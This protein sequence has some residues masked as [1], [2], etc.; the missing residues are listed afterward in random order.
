[1]TKDHIL[2][3]LEGLKD[4]VNASGKQAIDAIKA[5]VHV[6]QEAPP[7]ELIE[8]NGDEPAVVHIDEPE[9]AIAVEAKPKMRRKSKY[10]DRSP[11]HS[12][13]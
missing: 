9:E 7:Q 3:A 12:K 11:K 1:M 6:L 10:E 13:R 8:T 2:E 5:G 4:F